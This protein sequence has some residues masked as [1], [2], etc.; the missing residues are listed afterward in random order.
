MT[1]GCHARQE[2]PRKLGGSSPLIVASVLQQ[3]LLQLLQLFVTV[4]TVVAMPEV[5]EASE[6]TVV[7]SL[8]RRLWHALQNDDLD[9]VEAAW[10]A[11]RRHW[12][13]WMHRS[14]NKKRAVFRRNNNNKQPFVSTADRT[15][16]ILQLVLHPSEPFEMDDCGNPLQLEP[17]RSSFFRKSPSSLVQQWPDGYAPT[18]LLHEVARLGNL[19][20]LQ[21][22]LPQADVS[23]R[24]GHQRTLLH[25]VAGGGTTDP[26]GIVGKRSLPSNNNDRYLCLQT[27]LQHHQLSLN[28]IDSSGRTALHYA[29]SLGRADLCHLL[30]EH[31][32]TQLSIV[33]HNS[34]TPCELTKDPRLAARLEAQTLL[35]LEGPILPTPMPRQHPFSWFQTWDRNRVLL[36]RQGRLAEVQEVVAQLLPLLECGG[37]GALQ[38][39]FAHDDD[40]GNLEAIKAQLQQQQ[41][42]SQTRED[43]APLYHLHVT[44]W[45]QLLAFFRWDLQ[46]AMTFFLKSPWETLDLAHVVPTTTTRNT[47]D[48]E[49]DDRMCLICCDDQVD[50]DEW[51]VLSSCGHG[52]CADCLAGYLADVAESHREQGLVIACPHHECEVFMAPQQVQDWADPVVYQQLLQNAAEKFVVDAQDLRYCPHPDCGMVVWFQRPASILKAG[53]EME[54]LNAANA[55]CTGQCVSPDIDPTT[56]EGVYDPNY[57][58]CRTPT[59]PKQAHRFCFTCGMIPGHWPVS[60]DRILKWRGVIESHIQQVEGDGTTNFNELAHKLW[61]KANTRPCPY[62]RAPAVD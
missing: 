52:F 6:E 51:K 18:T 20:L 22:L 23:V 58:N 48:E 8:R 25:M 12:E 2:E 11:T 38:A 42:T 46:Q 37:K 30:L 57:L 10:T 16:K 4:V 49:E 21:S 55:V 24:N 19:R 61:L 39:V 40:E 50:E 53:L 60:C 33:D 44:Q 62:V 43:L 3:L 9:E 36:E 32:D 47:L 7:R 31:P 54:S 17:E 27:L 28:A 15:H 34:Q 14:K 45:E 5:T 35:T 29:S 41:P 1:R 13:D 56:Y 26:Q 59:Q